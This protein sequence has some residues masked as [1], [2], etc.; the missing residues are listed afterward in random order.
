MKYS[1]PK[2][3]LLVKDSLT[4]KKCWYVSCGAV[5]ST[6]RL[7]LG[8]KI[9]R[10]S[11]L[12]NKFHPIEFRTY[13]GEAELLVWCAWRLDK[14]ARTITSG[15]DKIESIIKR[16][17]ALTGK[18]VIDIEIHRPGWD[19]N[20]KFSSNYSLKIFCDFVPG[21]PSFQDNWVLSIPQKLLHVGPG[22]NYGVIKKDEVS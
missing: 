19:L 12:S 7:A 9:L 14:G 6:F 15:D 17:H 3:E 8:K 1:K 22:Q 13:E 2:F 20:I 21:D 4:N 18:K 5:G 11:P 16:L 10:K